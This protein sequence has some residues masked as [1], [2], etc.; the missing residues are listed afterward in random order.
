MM[1]A[2]KRIFSYIEEKFG[3]QGERIFDKP[4]EIAVFRHA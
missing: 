1:P 4:P 2:R 3:A